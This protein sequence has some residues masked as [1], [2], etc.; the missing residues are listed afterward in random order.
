MKN[1]KRELILKSA[2]ELM[3]ATSVDNVSISRIA[4]NAGIGKG[5]VYYYFQSKEEIIAEVISNSYKKALSEYFSDM[6]SELP[7]L[8]KIKRLFLSIIKKQFGDDRKNLIIAL[9]LHD[10][11]MLHNKM[12]LTAIEVVSPVL[13]G[14]LYQGIEEGTI[15]CE[16]PEES[17]EMIVAVISFLFDPSLFP[18]DERKMQSKLKLLAKV[19]ETCLQTSP[20][21][22]DFLFD[23]DA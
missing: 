4:K 23:A 14:L 9:N 12:K 8:E 10:S 20:G 11:P 21:S 7:A 2:E 1:D 19:L 16:A 18:T 22:F 13:S 5:S 3:S 15:N 17:A 6:K